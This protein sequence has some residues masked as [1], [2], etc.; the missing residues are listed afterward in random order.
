MI[1]TLQERNF[2][3]CLWES[4]CIDVRTS[5]YREAVEKGYLLKRK[6]GTPFIANLVWVSPARKK[7]S[8]EYKERTYDPG[9][10]IDF[11]NPDAV[12]WWKAKHRTL[13]D[14]GVATFKSDFGE[15]IP[16][17]THFFNG[18]TGKEMHNA[19]PLLYHNTTFETIAEFTE[20]PT[21]LCGRAGFAGSQRMP[22]QWDGDP[23]G[24]FPS[25]ASTIRAGLSYGMSGVPFWA[26]L[27]GGFESGNNP[28]EQYVRWVQ[29]GLLISHGLYQ[30]S[31]GVLPWVHGEEVFQI[32]KKF[33]ELRYRL[34][35]YIYAV[36]SEASKC[37][38]PVMRPL[39]LEFEDDPG[40]LATDLEYMLGPFLLITPVLNA[41]GMVNVYLPPGT[42]YDLWDGQEAH[43]P[44]VQRL[45]IGL[46]RVP[47]YVRADAILPTAEAGDTIPDLWDPL[48]IE[49]YPQASGR[50]EIPEER[51]RPATVIAV[52]HGQGMTIEAHGPERV[53][54]FLVRGVVEE[55]SHVTISSRGD[56]E[57]A[58]IEERNCLEV[59]AG[60]T[61][62]VEVQVG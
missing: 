28:R 10:I 13:L 27:L 41:E 22:V 19:Y 12:E 30:G 33:H 48:T 38:V 9:G 29:T 40:S 16:E 26:I 25:L 42:W 58:H 53:W 6:D 1:D 45:T 3:L 47:I 46:D 62:H 14:M 50:L 61:Q 8:Q 34:L 21:L 4:P 51:G 18:K 49:V 11:S 54:R 60:P 20:R 7:Q 59:T 23:A 2:K 56:T 55:P 31:A 36:S 17:D 44:G 37:G 32:V 15:E 39:V 5:M 57:W 43:G 24:D 35:P 52:S